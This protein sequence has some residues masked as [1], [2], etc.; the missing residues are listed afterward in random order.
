LNGLPTIP[1]IVPDLANVVSIRQLA[2]SRNLPNCFLADAA[3]VFTLLAIAAGLFRG[4]EVVSFCESDITVSV[5]SQ[6]VVF[7]CSVQ[8]NARQL[9]AH[10]RP[11]PAAACLLVGVSTLFRIRATDSAPSPRLINPIGG[12]KGP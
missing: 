12:V 3:G 11:G 9:H 4:A 1:I 8:A 10:S 6:P 2:G 7:L 5:E